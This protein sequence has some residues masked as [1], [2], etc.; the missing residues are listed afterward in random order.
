MSEE[1]KHEQTSPSKEKPAYGGQAL[2]EG[3]MFAGKE[4]TV[5]AIRRNTGDI[6]YFENV[7]KPM[8]TLQKLKKIPFVRGTVAL[9]EAAA[10]GSKHMNFASDRY[11]VHPDDDENIVTEEQR[12]KIVSF[13]GVAAM[14]VFA[15]LIGTVI[16]TLVPVFLAELL[17]GPFPGHVAQN[18]LEGL[19]KTIILVGYIYLISLTPLIKRVFQY[20]GAEHKV[21]NTYESNK[22]LTVENVQEHSRLHY[23]CGS[24]FMLFTVIIG[25][26]IYLLVP[27]DNLFERIVHRL[28]L[29]PVVLGV[30]YEVL[31]F[32]NKLRDIPVLKWLG[33][34][35]LWL[36][37]LTTKQPKDDQVEVSIAS[38]EKLLERDEQL[39]AEKAGSNIV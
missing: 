14:A 13:I 2:I 39:K 21:I 12:S 37:L 16:F 34:P 31:Q 9:I 4:T 28:L 20:H 30:S 11:D 18:L 36:Q 8:P 6:E 3:V 15:F 38:F 25:V 23:R 10:M 19:F 1:Q 33:L 17:S 26:M 35:G 27:F 32:T 7:R 24:S 5:S 29:I 22:P